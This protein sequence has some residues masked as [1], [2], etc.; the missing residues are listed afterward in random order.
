MVDS[1]RE[2]NKKKI[3]TGFLQTYIFDFSCVAKTEQ[4][5]GLY[6]A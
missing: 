3:S 5:V 6:T 4:N 1:V 2:I